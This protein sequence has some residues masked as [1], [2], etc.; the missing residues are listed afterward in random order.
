MSVVGMGYRTIKTAVGAGLAIWL[1]SLFNLEF[2]TFSAIIVIMCIER[3]KK[4]TLLT[5]NEKFFASLLSLVFG[6]IFFELIGYHPVVFSL[7]ILL[8][9]RS[10]FCCLFLYL[11]SSIF[12]AV[13]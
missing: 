4:R 11:S 7:F 2:A 8:F 10:L 5:M 9:F 1:A 6:A 12:R 3:T 13:L